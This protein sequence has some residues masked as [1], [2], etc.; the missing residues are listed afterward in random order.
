MIGIR[1]SVIFLHQTLTFYHVRNALNICGFLA[2]HG[3]Q[4]ANINRSHT[5]LLLPL[6]LAIRTFTDKK[7][8]INPKP[9]N[10]FL[11]HLQC[12]ESVADMTGY[13]IQTLKIE[14]N[15]VQQ[16]FPSL[17]LKMEPTGINCLN[18]TWCKRHLCV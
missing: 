13:A 12:R 9:L 14:Q 5:L 18:N 8:F 17:G 15:L 6:T 2:I 3:H 10:N 7:W 1:F 16:M 11:Y 4:K